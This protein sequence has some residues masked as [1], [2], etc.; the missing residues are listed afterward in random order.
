MHAFN[1]G[2]SPSNYFV[3]GVICG[4]LHKLLFHPLPGL[5]HNSR[6]NCDLC[7]LRHRKMDHLHHPS[8]RMLRDM[9]TG[10][11]KFNRGCALGKYTKTAFPNNGNKLIGVLDLIHYDLCGPM[12]FVS[13]T[14]FDYYVTLIDNFSRNI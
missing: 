8:L 12:S 13:L 4:K 2:L 10:L 6:N 3:I 1:K 5:E 7:E 14:G 11:S 9:V